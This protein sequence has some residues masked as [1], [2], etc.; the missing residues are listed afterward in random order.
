MIVIV[1]FGM[2]NLRSIQH[3]LEKAGVES[4]ISSEV[5]VIKEAHK[6]ILPGVGHFAT[7]MKNLIQFKLIDILNEKILQE[8]VPILGIC[9]GMQLFTQ[10]S[11]EGRQSGLG[12]IK[13]KAIKF[14]YDQ[15]NNLRVPHVGWNKIALKKDSTLFNRVNV[16]H[17]FYFTHSYYVSCES[18]DDVIATTTYG[19]E[20][21]SVI[22]KDNIFGTQFHPEKSHLNGFEIIKNFI[23]I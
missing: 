4:R 13:A 21:V 5:N 12:W 1:D 19:I 9:L 23:R 3:K 2:G 14:E 7:G 16:E 8:K 20:F 10:H 22:Q 15:N 6:I 17:R 11:E 18:M